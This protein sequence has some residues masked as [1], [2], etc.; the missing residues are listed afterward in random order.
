MVAGRLEA[1]RGLKV[2][3]VEDEYLIAMA[4]SDELEACG[5]FVLGMA[6]TIES[7]LVTIAGDSPDA[8]VL[9]VELQGRLMTPI[10]EELAK[11]GIPYI[12]TTGHDS[13]ALP[14]EYLAVPRCTKPT[15]AAHVLDTLCTVLPT[16]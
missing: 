15:T 5:A 10:A 12:L 14:I 8:A 11:R 16:R 9:D 2:L 3:V 7:A 6:S 1:L 4:L 13:A